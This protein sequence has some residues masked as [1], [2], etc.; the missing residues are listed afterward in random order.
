MT[1]DGGRGT[2]DGDQRSDVRSRKVTKEIKNLCGVSVLCGELF[3]MEDK[4][5]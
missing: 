4:N 5:I 1:E 2:E 3:S